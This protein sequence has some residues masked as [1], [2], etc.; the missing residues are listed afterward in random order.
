MKELMAAIAG[1]RS[2]GIYQTLTPIEVNAL[3]QPLQTEGVE[4]FYLDGT[5]IAS[6]ADFLNALA[7][8]LN[9]PDYFGHNWDALADCLTDMGWQGGDR[10]LLLYTHPEHF[11]QADPAAWSTALEIL[12]EA[13]EFWHNTG[14]SLYVVLQSNQRVNDLAML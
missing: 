4:F 14:T 5:A 8:A 12:Q 13:I 6:K 3:T 9:F 2:P 11:A 1:D 7:T 10:A